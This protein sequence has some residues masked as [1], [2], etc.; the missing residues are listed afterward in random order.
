[1]KIIILISYCVVS[2]TVA[3]FSA[4]AAGYSDKKS[5]EIM[6]KTFGT[7]TVSEDK[8]KLKI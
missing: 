3:M 5:D 7:L 2:L 1:M 6:E 4:I 8:T